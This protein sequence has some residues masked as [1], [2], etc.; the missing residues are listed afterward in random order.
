MTKPWNFVKSFERKSFEQSSKDTNNSVP[1]KETYEINT[2]YLNEIKIK[3]IEE[4]RRVRE[5]IESEI[6]LP[7]EEPVV[8]VIVPVEKPKRKKGR[9][10]EKRKKSS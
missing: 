5:I 4:E 7:L 9:K 2:D 3:Q 8:E 1:E 10:N 6:V